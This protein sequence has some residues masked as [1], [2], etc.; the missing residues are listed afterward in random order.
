VPTT[1]QKHSTNLQAPDV[2]NLFVLFNF[3][4]RGRR[5]CGIVSTLESEPTLISEMKEAYEAEARA[6]VSELVSRI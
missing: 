5:A 6:N 2:A 3:W 4:G 1:C